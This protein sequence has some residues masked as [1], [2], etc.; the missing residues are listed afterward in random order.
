MYTFDYVAEKVVREFEEVF[1]EICSTNNEPTF[2]IVPKKD[3]PSFKANA[4]NEIFGKQMVS[5][6]KMT[7]SI[8]GMTAVA[9]TI[10]VHCQQN[11][12]IRVVIPYI[13]VFAETLFPIM[14]SDQKL[15]SNI[16]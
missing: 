16:S 6:E 14:A 12:F 8:D 1:G 10:T 3:F 9:E 7:E 5:P 11:G 4:I 2:A 15:N 13:T